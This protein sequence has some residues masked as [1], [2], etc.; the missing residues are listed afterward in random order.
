MEKKKVTESILGP[1]GR[2]VG[3]SKGRYRWKNPRNVVIFNANVCTKT[4]KLWY[5]DI[6]LSTNDRN[7]LRS[8]AKELG[9]PVYVLYELSARFEKETTFDA[10]D[11]PYFTDGHTDSYKDA[12]ITVDAEGTPLYPEEEKK[13]VSEVNHIPRSFNIK[14]CTIIPHKGFQKGTKKDSPMLLMYQH[15]CKILKVDVKDLQCS[16]VYLPDPLYKELESLEKAWIAKYHKEWDEYDLNKATSWHW[17]NYGPNSLGTGNESVDNNNIY[18][19]KEYLNE[20][21]F[22]IGSTSGDYH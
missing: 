5:G 17:F 15:I 16:W 2:M 7:K 21:M 9:E 1:S 14:K 22:N 20:D 4:E 13:E 19:K 8:L 11:A 6:D 10:T 3:A 12:Q 18:V